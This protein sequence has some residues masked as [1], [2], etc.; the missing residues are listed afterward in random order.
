LD[1]FNAGLTIPSVRTL[2]IDPMTPGRMYAGTDGG[3]VFAIEQVAGTGGGGCTVTADHSSGTAWW[4]LVP[5][6]VLARR[7]RSVR[8][9]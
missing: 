6:L 2:T 5:A 1:A 4:L 9:P 7:R 8:R 3:G